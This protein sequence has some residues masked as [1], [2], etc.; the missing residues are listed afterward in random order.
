MN[1]LGALAV[2][3]G[4][5]TGL[6]SLAQPSLS[7]KP[8][9]VA[10]A[11]K[12]VGSNVVLQGTVTRVQKT[13][14]AIRLRFE[15]SDA[16]EIFAGLV[17]GQSSNVFTNLDSLPGKVVTLS[18]K[19]VEVDGLPAMILAASAQLKVLGTRPLPP[20]GLRIVPGR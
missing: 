6:S 19:V 12:L 14:Q 10:E 11:S 18:G 3:F 15:S 20:G 8:I 16:R 7:V 5:L 17:P 2:V 4:V 1:A 13:G 9:P